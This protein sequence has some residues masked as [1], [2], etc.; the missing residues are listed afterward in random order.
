MFANSGKLLH[1]TFRIPTGSS[2][3]G[4][5]TVYVCDI[6]QPSLSTYYSALVSVNVFMALSTEF[7]SINSPDNSPFF[8]SVLPVLSLP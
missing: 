3:R 4:Y 2:S 1:A 7:Y 6:N 8:H 5:V